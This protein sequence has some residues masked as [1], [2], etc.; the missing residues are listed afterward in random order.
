[1]TIRRAK[2]LYYRRQFEKNAGNPKR[3]WSDLLEAIQKSKKFTKPARMFE[4]DNTVVTEPKD[5]VES[6][7]NY[8]SH[9]A[10]KLDASLGPSNTDPISYMSDVTAPGVMSFS[11]VSEEYVRLLVSNLKDVGAGLDGINVKMFKLVLPSILKEVTHLV[12]ICISKSVFPSNLKVA[13]IT[14]IHKSGSQSLFSNYRPISVLPVLSKVLETIMYNQ[15]IG[16]FTEHN[17]IF[18]YQFGFRSNHSTYMP[19]SLLHDKVTSCLVDGKVSAGIYLD[20]ARAFDTVNTNIL[21]QK[22]SKYG[23]IG[24]SLNLLTSYLTDRSHRL[25]YEDMISSAQNITCGVPQGSVLG[26]LLFLIYINDIRFACQEAQLLLF[27]DDTA[28]FY[29][30]SS[31][32]EL[33][34]IIT[35]SFPKITAWLHAS[36]LSLSIP[37]TFYQIY[38]PGGT[39]QTLRIPVENSYLHRAQTVKYLGILVDEDLKFKSHIDKVSTTISRNL[40]IISRAKYLLSKNLRLMLYNALILPYITY[41]LPVWG[42]NYESTLQS[43]V[44][45]QKRAIR[46]I[47][48]AAPLAH[49]SP[50]FKELNVLKLNDLLKYQI[51]LI[52]HNVLFGHAPKVITDKFSL[53][54]ATR[55]TRTQQHFNV[56]IPSSSS[57]RPTPNYRCYNYRLFCLFCKGPVIWNEIVA[58]NIPNLNDIPPSKSFFKKC[59][60]KLLTE[61]Y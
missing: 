25:K 9:V 61:T 15:L 43:V 59:M 23:I 21:L 35:A 8:Y 7:N 42:S 22:L 46:M 45:A 53:H 19:L 37:K 40:G 50:L 6:F 56:T 54:A 60:K 28:I 4:V 41:C 18:D 12:N 1:M 55:P 14:P 20:L 51:L 26:P 47:A 33:Q 52:M 10:K 17:I 36:R 29:T 38:A 34:S 27:A 44:I 11:N 13:L 3:L 24:D 32:T 39:T 30:A 49:S 57:G 58:C 5:I 48:G 31:L 16:F 2:R